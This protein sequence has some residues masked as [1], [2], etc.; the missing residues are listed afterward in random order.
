MKACRLSE[1]KS[2]PSPRQIRPFELDE[3]RQQKHV[4]QL[5]TGRMCA[6]ALPTT[7]ISRRAGSTQSEFVD[8]PPPLLLSAEPLKEF[9]AQTCLRDATA[10]SVLR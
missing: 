2:N 9:N 3:K 7:R 10:L 6:A 5:Q 1:I 8:E 4:N